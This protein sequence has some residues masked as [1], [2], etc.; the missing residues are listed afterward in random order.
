[1]AVNLRASLKDELKRHARAHE[2]LGSD[3]GR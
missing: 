2:L 3:Y 1:M